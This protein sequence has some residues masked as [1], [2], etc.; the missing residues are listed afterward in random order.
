LTQF[1]KGQFPDLSSL[2]MGW[3]KIGAMNSSP[4]PGSHVEVLKSR[5]EG[6]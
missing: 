1:D 3:G 6:K 4:S 5:G 2:K